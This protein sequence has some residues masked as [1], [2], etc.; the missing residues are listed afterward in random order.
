MPV[1]YF[2]R[3]WQQEGQCYPYWP[4]LFGASCPTLILGAI[5]FVNKKTKRM[6]V[7]YNN[8]N[9][10]R[11]QAFPPQTGLFT[12][13]AHTLRENMVQ[14]QMCRQWTFFTQSFPVLRGNKMDWKYFDDEKMY[15]YQTWRVF[16]SH[17][18]SLKTSYTAFVLSTYDLNAIGKYA[19]TLY[20][21]TQNHCRTWWLVYLY[22]PKGEHG[23]HLSWLLRIQ[24]FKMCQKT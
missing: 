8:L 11:G 7:F 2:P 24:N 15:W 16:N 22:I 23:T 10:K 13:P 9:E 21:Q 17:Y 6:K 20:V 3:D 19:N 18:H 12:T 1:E 14:G 4:W 5:A